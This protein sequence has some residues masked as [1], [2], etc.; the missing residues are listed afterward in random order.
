M[1]R[2]GAIKRIEAYFDDG[3]FFADLA[4]RVAIHT[5]SQEPAQRGELER[6]LSDEMQPS[7]E[8]LGFRCSI[9]PNPVARGGPFLV[10][11]RFEGA[12]MTINGG[13][14]SIPGC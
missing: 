13:T 14:G 8:A 4:R 10:A 11:T 2:T 1:S 7:F 3:G 12:A 9:Y 6:Y 5:E